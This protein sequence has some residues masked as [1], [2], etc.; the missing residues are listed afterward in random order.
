GRVADFL[1]KAEGVQVAG[2]FL[3]ERKLTKVSGIETMKLVQE[4]L[5]EIIINRVK[6]KEIN[7][8]TDQQLLHEFHQVFGDNTKLTLRD[9]SKIPQEASGKYRFSICK[10]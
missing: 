9:V 4:D 2:D 5:H 1:K 7:P 10:I 3:V 6:G 8:M